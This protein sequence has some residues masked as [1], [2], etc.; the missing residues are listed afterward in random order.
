MLPDVT[1]QEYSNKIIFISDISVKNYN[2]QILF[3]SDITLQKYSNQIIPNVICYFRK[4]LEVK[5]IFLCV[6]Y[7]N[8]VSIVLLQTEPTSRDTQLRVNFYRRSFITL[9]T[10]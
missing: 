10:S 2:N 5:E 6:S 7:F 3:L 4:A 9:H 1:P 8:S